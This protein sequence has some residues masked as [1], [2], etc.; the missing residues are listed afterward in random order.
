MISN[1]KFKE[2]IF[3]LIRGK[4]DF[5]ASIVVIFLFLWIGTTYLKDLNLA[6]ESIPNYYELTENSYESYERIT[7][8]KNIKE[9]IG[10]EQFIEMKYDENLVKEEDPQKKIDPFLKSF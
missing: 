9:L 2:K 7:S 4:K 5:L 8:R 1:F 3:K 6:I 10:N